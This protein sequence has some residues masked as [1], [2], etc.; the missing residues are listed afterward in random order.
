MYVRW[1]KVNALGYK[2]CNK[3]V[4]VFCKKKKKMLV[5]EIDK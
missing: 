2:I 3:L 4:E 5:L 1:V